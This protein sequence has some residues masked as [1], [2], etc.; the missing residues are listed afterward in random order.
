[1]IVTAYVFASNHSATWFL[2]AGV[3][4]DV[5]NTFTGTL[6]AYSGGQCFGCP[7]TS[8][9]GVASGTVSISFTSP[10]TG[11][12]LFPGGS[13]Q[14]QHEVFG[15][16][17]KTDYLLGEWSFS[18]GGGGII[19]TQWVVFSD[20]YT[21]SDG[22]VYAA[23]Q[24]DGISG[25]AALATYLPNENAFIVVIA[26]NAGYS[27][28]YVFSGDDRRLLGLGAIFSTGTTP[29]TPADVSAGSR[30]LFPS[31]LSGSPLSAPR[32]AS[33]QTTATSRDAMLGQ[34]DQMVQSARKSNV[35]AQLMR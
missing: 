19:S 21:G 35:T 5:H 29:P 33:V 16:T 32:I 30:L 18:L 20:H 14:I 4:D 25:T 8:P 9:S 17:N 7:Y 11:T 6:G 22:T 1:M 26:D 24:E 10:E 3:Y 31:E 2:A 13:T 12:M 15:Y 23:G 28:E 34:L 27:F